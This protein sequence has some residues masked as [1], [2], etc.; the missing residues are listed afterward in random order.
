VIPIHNIG[1]KLDK[2]RSHHRFIG[3]GVLVKHELGARFLL[4]RADFALVLA[5]YTPR[6]LVGNLKSML[7]RPLRRRRLHHLS[8]ADVLNRG[9]LLCRIIQRRGPDS[10]R[11]G[12]GGVVRALTRRWLGNVPSEAEFCG[13]RKEKKERTNGQRHRLLQI[14]SGASSP[15]QK[16]TLRLCGRTRQA[17]STPLHPGNFS[18]TEALRRRIQNCFRDPLNPD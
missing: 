7:L 12:R 6:A 10:I 17:C 1:G 16:S 18:T 5:D 3:K 4:N 15:Q 11:R 8:R 2:G 9:S 14:C 13:N